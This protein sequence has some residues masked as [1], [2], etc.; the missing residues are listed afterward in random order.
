MQ[1]YEGCPW[2]PRDPGRNRLKPMCYCI[3]LHYCVVKMRI[4]LYAKAF[5]SI[6]KIEGV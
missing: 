1:G 2:I 3:L 6:K 4:V 5:S